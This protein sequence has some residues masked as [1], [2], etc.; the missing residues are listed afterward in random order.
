MTT[1]SKS[2]LTEAEKVELAACESIVDSGIQSFVE[3]GNALMKIAEGRLYRST[4][5]TFEPYVRER[6]QM[7]ARH[8]YRLC[9]AAKVVNDL[10][11]IGHNLQ[12]EAQARELAKVEPEKRVEV[13]EK[14]AAKGPVTAKTI[15]ESAKPEPAPITFDAQWKT[16]L[17]NP[18]TVEVPD[19][20]E[21]IRDMLR[22]AWYQANEETKAWFRKHI[23]PQTP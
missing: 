16:A 13:L 14:A 23:T 17:G 15:R 2:E 22:Q 19:D 11:P 3:V 7:S 21:S 5:G 18:E 9:E 4:H 20:Q 6:Y 1:L 12:S 10:R 8:A